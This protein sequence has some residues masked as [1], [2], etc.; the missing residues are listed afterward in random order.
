MSQIRMK[1][2]LALA[3]LSS[4]ALPMAAQAST[5]RV[6]G[7]ALQGDY[8]KDETGI[9]TYTNEVANVGNFIYGEMGDWQGAIA[10]PNDRAVGA[11]L[12]NLWDGRFGAWGIHMRETTPQLG[13][14]D[15]TSSPSPGLNDPN[16]NAWQSFD[17]QWGKKFGTKSLGLHM[18]RSFGKIEGDN[19]S[20]GP[21]SIFKGGFT[22]PV[23]PAPGIPTPLDANTFRNIFGLGGG[24][25]W[26]MGS[27]TNAE[28]SVLWE[29]RTY[30]VRD[31]LGADLFK[32]DG[33]TTWQFAGR[34]FWQW[35]PNVMVVPVFKYTKYDLSDKTPAQSF[36]NSITAWQ[37]GMAGNWTLG[38]NDLFVLGLTFAQNKLDQQRDVLGIGFGNGTVTETFTPEIFA[39]LETHINPWLTLRF[40]ADKGA[41]HSVKFEDKDTPSSTRFENSPFFMTLGAGIKL[42]TL[43]LDAVLNDHIAQNGLYLLSGSANTPLA[44]KVTATYAF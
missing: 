21:L 17:L 9:Y 3:A 44:S 40:G 23:I 32:D 42:G 39:A 4:L 10:T 29:S 7:M 18:N 28:V 43:Q 22:N 26:E 34:M 38:S 33:P 36:D 6:E 12:G 11:V 14:G 1:A 24:F 30:E 5:S 27:N 13:Q 41:W 37:A 35:Q 8:I 25:G 16:T 2:I 31:T 15:A 19:G 20:L